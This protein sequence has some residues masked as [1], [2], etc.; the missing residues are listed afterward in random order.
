MTTDTNGAMKDESA[1]IRMGYIQVG[2]KTD[3]DGRAILLFDFR[4]DGTDVSSATILRVVWHQVHTALKQESVQ[5]RV[6][7][8][9]C[10]SVEKLSD[11]RPSLRKSLAQAGRGICPYALQECTS[12]EHLRSLK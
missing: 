8:I 6:V 1:A 5:K 9:Y 12:F 7:V 4:K 11:W 10:H 2:K 3:P